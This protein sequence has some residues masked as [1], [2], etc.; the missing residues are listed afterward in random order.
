MRSKEIG[1]MTLAMVGSTINQK[2]LFGHF[3]Y[4]IIDECHL[5]DHER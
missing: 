2:G 5:V 3:D 1:K 4:I